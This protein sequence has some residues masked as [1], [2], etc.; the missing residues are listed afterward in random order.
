MWMVFLEL[1]G[2]GSG[3]GVERK[4]VVSQKDLEI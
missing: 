1:C 3:E 4:K 2:P